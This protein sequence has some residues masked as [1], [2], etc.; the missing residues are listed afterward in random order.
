MTFTRNVLEIKWVT[1][2]KKKLITYGEIE[3]KHINNNL[4]KISYDQ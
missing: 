4:V 1:I 2:I 3:I